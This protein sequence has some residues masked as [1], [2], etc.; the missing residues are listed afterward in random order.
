MTRS[1]TALTGIYLALLVAATGCETDDSETDAASESESTTHDDGIA[2]DSTQFGSVAVLLE[3]D[4][5]C[6]QPF[7]NTH[8]ITISIEYSECVG[9]IYRS[10]PELG[11][12]GEKGQLIHKEWASRLCAP[13]DSED[14]VAG[15]YA[16]CSVVADSWQQSI[17]S[18]LGGTLEYQ[19][20]VANDALDGKLLRLG[21]LPKAALARDC[22]PE[23]ELVPLSIRG[24][25]A[26]GDLRW[27][28][29]PTEPTVGQPASALAM[30]TSV[31]G[32]DSLICR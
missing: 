6:T 7:A 1:W 24:F 9:W 31:V 19:I 18:F 11:L 20:I 8:S 22:T 5:D 23:I 21:P 25:D 32:G 16:E 3:A 29:T 26:S 30:Q 28:A 15:E 13:T 27:R 12:E 17:H 10:T 2:D 14:T 4:P